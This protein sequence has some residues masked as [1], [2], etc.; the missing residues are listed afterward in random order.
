MAFKER[1]DK[2]HIVHQWYGELPVESIY[3]V[4]VAGEKFFRH[5]KDN[6]K[7]LGIRC[8]KCEIVY[9]PPRI[10]CE[11]CFNELKEYIE[12]SECG[13]LESF[14]T[15]YFDLKGQPLEKPIIVGLINL[16][17]SSTCIVHKLGECSVEE[18]CFGMRVCA[19]L[20]PQPEREGSINDILYFKPTNK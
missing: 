15:I 10:Y 1:I 20:K 9:V 18:L 17:G 12:V 11:R 14:T 4:G 19:V 13:T 6:G 8:P 5:I 16:D 3:T 2:P 7:F